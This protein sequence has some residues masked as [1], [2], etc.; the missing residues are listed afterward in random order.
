V[1]SPPS[2][3]GG[4]H[5]SSADG[6]SGPRKLAVTAREERG[7]RWGSVQGLTRGGGATWRPGDGGKDSAATVLSES[8]AQAWREEKRSGERCG[9][10]RGWC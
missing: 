9:E 4:A 3:T 10:T 6:C 7:A 2:P 5:W 1:D 8:A